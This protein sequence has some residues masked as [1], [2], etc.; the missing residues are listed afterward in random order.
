[1]ERLKRLLNFVLND[2]CPDPKPKKKKRPSP[3]IPPKVVLEVFERDGY[4]CQYCPNQYIP[5]QHQLH[6]HHR[7]FKKM[8]RTPKR[9]DNPE[10]LAACC[11]ECHGKHGQLKG[12]KTLSESDYTIIHYLERK[13]K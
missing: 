9:W 11:F 13:Y 7:V 4:R 8:G 1:M 2:F 3:A 5:G 12:A 10:N 6:C